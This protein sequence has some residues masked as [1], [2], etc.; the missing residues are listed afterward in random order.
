MLQ[1]PGCFVFY[2]LAAFIGLAMFIGWVNETRASATTPTSF[3]DRQQNVAAVVAPTASATLP[4]T[5]DTF[6]T[7]VAQGHDA[8]TQRA[9]TWTAQIAE[10][11]Q[12]QTQTAGQWTATAINDE[13]T[14]VSASKTEQALRVSILVE[15]LTAIPP[16]QTM[17]SD[18]RA[19][20]AATDWQHGNQTATVEARERDQAEV[21]D[22]AVQI[23]SIGLTCSA[24]AVILYGLYAV[25]AAM[26]WWIKGQRGGAAQAEV[27]A[28]G[29]SGEA[30]TVETREPIPTTTAGEPSAPL[31]RYTPLEHLTL[32]ALARMSRPEMGGP[33][34]PM[35]TSA[36]TFGDNRTRDKVRDALIASGLAVS[37][38]GV[39]VELVEP[40]TVG[41]LAQA[42]AD[43]E[44]TLT[45]PPTPVGAA[46]NN[47]TGK[48][49]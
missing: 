12:A 25:F 27:I 35:L 15:T 44:I 42:I 24:P 14:R 22:D 21:L 13:A 36:P 6:A 4:A 31:S 3:A 11:S 9:A 34:A 41:S 28:A 46:Q 39:G 49:R 5:V 45:D 26:G 7:M 16:A 17:T 29:Y 38:N 10:T 33:D 47:L 43:G 19:V 20:A 1:R 2:V 32:R 48:V 40:W 8:E 23:A 37:V 18:A 30:Q